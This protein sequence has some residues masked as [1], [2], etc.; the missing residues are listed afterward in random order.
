MLHTTEQTLE[1][2]FN[3][4]VGKDD[5]VERVKKL[6]DYAFIHYRDRMDALEAMHVMNGLC[7]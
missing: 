7:N 4:A 1:Q 5:A 6:R 3:Q 2:A